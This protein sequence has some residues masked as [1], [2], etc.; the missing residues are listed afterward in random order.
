[1][2]AS[3]TLDK[4]G[5]EL[6][7]KRFEDPTIKSEL[8]KLPQKKA[9]AAL[10]AQAIADNFD[11]EGPGWAPLKADTIR[12]S[13]AKKI[14]KHLSTMTDN[15]ILAFEKKA[16]KEGTP[17]NFVGP[18][19][20]ILQKTRLLYG[21]VTTPGANIS[22]NGMSGSNIWRTEGS[23][24]IWGTDLI[25]AATHNEGNPSKNI[26][27]REFLVLRSEW[28]RRLN[29]FLLEEITQIVTSRLKGAT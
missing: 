7:I 15:E 20:K 19:R 14:K 25:Y 27:K 17:E 26:P 3:L 4:S 28:L 21:T 8:E 12:R 23:N 29:E 6:L 13:V 1:M 16:R 22:K 18:N 5:L 24:L 10:V 11:K 2:S 9:I